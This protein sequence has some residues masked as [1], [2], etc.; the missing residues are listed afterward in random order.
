MGDT[1]E[2]ETVSSP[3][4]HGGVVTRQVSNVSMPKV[5]SGS[6]GTGSNLVNSIVGAGMYVDFMCPFIHCST[7]YQ[8]LVRSPF[9]AVLLFFCSIG[10]PYAIRNAGIIAGILLLV[11]VSYMT[12]KSLRI[13]IELA[14]FHPKLKNLVVHT[15]EDLMSIPFGRAGTL[16]VL[17]NMYVTCE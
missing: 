9:Y 7:L 16:F 17:V 11:L 10:I 2:E 8:K 4:N 12:D 5:K 1:P 6:F 13:L 3:Q 15:Y 14:N